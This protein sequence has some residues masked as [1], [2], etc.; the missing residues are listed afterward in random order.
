[1]QNK[2]FGPQN[3]WERTEDSVE[4]LQG[5]T[6]RQAQNLLDEYGENVIRSSAKAGVLKLFAGQFKDAM[7]LILLAATV[8]SAFLGEIS[9]AFTIIIIVFVNALLGFFQEFRTEKTLEKLGEMAAPT[10]SVIRDGELSNIPASQVVPGDLFCLKAGDRVP[11]DGLVLEAQELC[12]DESMLSGESIPIEKFPCSGLSDPPKASQ[13]YMGTMVPRGKA[14]CRVRATGAN[15]E[16]GKIADMLGGIEA[17]PTPLQ[18]RLAHMSRIIG[19]GCLIICFVVALAGILRGEDPFSMVLVGI[20]LAVAAIPEGLP[21]VVTIALALSVGRMVRR[22]ALIRRLHAV[23]TLGCANVICSDKTGTLTENRMTV[24]VLQ[25]PNICVEVGG[26]GM[27][28]NGSFTQDGRSIRPTERSDLMCLLDIS[29][30]CNNADISP[31]DKGSAQLRTV[32][33]PTEAALLVLAAK[34]GIYRENRPYRIGREVPFDSTR[35]MMSLGVRREDGQAFL[36]CKGAPDLLLERCT[37]YLSSNGSRP[38]SPSIRKRIL[39]WNDQMASQALRVLG[40]AFRKAGSESDVVEQNLVFV[41]L[42][43]MI[44]PPRPEALEAV[45][46]CRQAG[47]RPIMIT[48]DHAITARAI[49]CD[50]GIC[51][52][53]GRVVTGKELDTMSDDQL[54]RQIPDISVFARVTPAHK[55]RIVRAL[56]RQ[57]NIVAMT[58]DGVNDAPAIKEADIG[59][60]MGITGT[61]VT[62]EASSVVLMDDNFATLVAAV[63]EGRVIYQ[64]IRKFIRYLFS[65]NIGEVVT[66]FFAML[67]GMPVPLLPIQILL[68]NLATDGLPAI[69]LGLEPAEE[70]VMRQKPRRADESVFSNGLAFT[71]V[72]RGLLIGLCTLGVFVSLYKSSFGDIA[73]ART[74]ALTALVLMQLIHVFECKSERKGLFSIPFFNNWKLIGAALISLGLLCLALWH[75]L[76]STLFQTVPL[77]FSQLRTVLCYCLFVPLLS[78][79]VMSVRRRGGLRTES[80]NSDPLPLLK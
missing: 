70:D 72:I 60:A 20:S 32:G 71:I 15:T 21:A 29:I 49:A 3:Q 76:L 8:L 67:M 7:V 35:K 69:A 26:S 47:I 61:D 5:L 53:D 41:G 14:I 80:T 2:L 13:V 44:D 38:L 24:R 51:P 63:E 18:K 9:E 12:C 57:G 31:I 46:K 34:A 79:I 43:G 77:S 17:Q 65:C 55:L 11:A 48:G 54:A 1:M 30:L 66:M 25:T 27:E 42:A 36:F 23:E 68:V 37:H 52:V 19:I 62:K 50:L 45:H 6:N 75:P 16:M 28:S 58:G 64:N 4:K 56:K 59:V 78:G 33:E 10:A 40:F 74:G 39:Q 73:L 22:G